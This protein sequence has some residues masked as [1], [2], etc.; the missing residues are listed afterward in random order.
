MKRRYNKL[1]SNIH[2]RYLKLARGRVGLSIRQYLSP[3]FLTMLLASLLLWYIA[4]LTYTYTTE[5]EVRVKLEDSTFLTRCVVEG[6][7]THLVGY[8]IGRQVMNIPLTELS[9]SVEID[10]DS[11]RY[12][13]L[14]ENTFVNA[15]S[16]RCSD[17]KVVS[18]DVP[19]RVDMTPKIERLTTA[20]K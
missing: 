3:I 8:N 2:T 9:Y 20:V 19:S 18:V 13:R 4:K 1:K 11:V 14:S 6:V 17:I 7:G 16:V 15:I 10:S 12:L 5:I